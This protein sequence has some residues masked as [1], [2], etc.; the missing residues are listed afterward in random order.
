MRP[1]QLALSIERAKKGIFLGGGILAYEIKQ[2]HKKRVPVAVKTVY[3]GNIARSESAEVK[4][5][6]ILKFMKKSHMTVEDIAE[7]TGENAHATRSRL[8]ILESRRQVKPMG[9]RGAFTLWGLA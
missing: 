8:L 2:G 9:K 6:E 4:R 1:E 7:K 5:K 3:V